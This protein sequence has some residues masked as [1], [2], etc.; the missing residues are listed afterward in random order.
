MVYPVGGDGA[1]VRL[2]RTGPPEAYGDEGPLSSTPESPPKER[3][4]KLLM[5]SN[6][7]RQRRWYWVVGGVTD[8]RGEESMASADW[9]D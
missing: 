4:T 3:K 6:R 2:A 1:G 5:E 8:V 9:K 7:R